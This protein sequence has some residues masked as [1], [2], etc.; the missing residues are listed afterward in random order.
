[1]ERS[2]EVVEKEIELFRNRE[3]RMFK[4]GLVLTIVFGVLTALSLISFI[5]AVFY[6]VMSDSGLIHI[7]SLSDLTSAIIGVY[8]WCLYSLI[9]FSVSVV[10]LCVGVAL[11]IVAKAVFGG[12]AAK[13]EIELINLR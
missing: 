10:A 6:A 7:T 9:L 8:L 1:M 3:R 13:R 2:K 11:M 5:A 4:P 12:K